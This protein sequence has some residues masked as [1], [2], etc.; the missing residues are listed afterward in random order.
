MD[1]PQAD[2]PPERSADVL[3]RIAGAAIATLTLSYAPLCN[4]LLFLHGQNTLKLTDFPVFCDDNQS[5]QL[6]VLSLQR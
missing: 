4:G 2:D 5:P 6:R 1:S 3:S